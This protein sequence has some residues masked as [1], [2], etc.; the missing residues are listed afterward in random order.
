MLGVVDVE[1]VVQCIASQLS[2]H[3]VA[4]DALGA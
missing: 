3:F 1:A 4:S 2:T